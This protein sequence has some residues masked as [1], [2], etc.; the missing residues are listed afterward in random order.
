MKIKSILVGLS[1]LLL[2]SQAYAHS[3]FMSLT[4]IDDNKI[5]LEG[6]Y[7]TGEMAV[8]T[9]VKIYRTKDNSLIWQ[10]E[11][12]ELGTCIFTRPPEPYE[13]ELDAGPGH[14]VRED[15]I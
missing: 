15:G 2:S 3:L 12:D 4:D 14:Q 7:S 8:K 9:P 6:M 1:I 10:G 11:T 5:E 13:V